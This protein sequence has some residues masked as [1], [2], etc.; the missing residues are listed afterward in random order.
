MDNLHTLNWWVDASYTVH[1]DSLIHTC[2][3]M[4]M[5]FGADMS[6]SWRQKLNT[7]SSNEDELV[8]IDDTLHTS[9]GSCIYFN[10]KAMK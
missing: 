9:Y 7:G 5:G 8:G 10:H 1:W 2:M 6:G 4:S 3:V